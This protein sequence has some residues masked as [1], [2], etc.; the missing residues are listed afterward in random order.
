MD[1][2]KLKEILEQ[3]KLWV[4]TK[5]LK[6][7]RADLRRLNLEGANFEGFDLEG[8]K[9]FGARLK[10]ANFEGARLKGANFEG[11]DFEGANFEG[12]KNLPEHLKVRTEMYEYKATCIKVVDGDTLDL[13]ID[14]GLKIFTRQRVRLK[15]INTPEIRGL[16]REEGL[17]AKEFVENFLFFS[18]SFHHLFMRSKPLTI[19]TFKDKQGKYGRWIVDVFNS[20]GASL[21]DQLLEKGLA[22]KVSY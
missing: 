21:C 3:H 4:E 15:G 2:E 1:K 22:K 13:E 17:K 19:K 8:V 5:G 18:S 7:E 16:E 10:G 11:A 20:A 12:A 9:L 6:G 14:L